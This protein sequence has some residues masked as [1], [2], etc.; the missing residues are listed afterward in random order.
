MNYELKID[1]NLPENITNNLSPD[2]TNYLTWQTFRIKMVREDMP[3]KLSWLL[4]QARKGY[5]YAFKCAIRE[6]NERWFIISLATVKRT[7]FSFDKYYVHA[8]KTQLRI[9]S[10]PIIPRKLQLSI[11]QSEKTCDTC[12]RYLLVNI[13]C[14]NCQGLFTNLHSAIDFAEQDTISLVTATQLM[15]QTIDEQCDQCT[16]E[17]LHCRHLIAPPAQL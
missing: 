13:G 7:P 11:Q 12:N 3:V 2:I 10:P 16:R 5:L 17:K 9:R 1:P 4:D 8:E 15:F 14:F 6:L